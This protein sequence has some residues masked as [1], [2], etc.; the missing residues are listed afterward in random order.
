MPVLQPSREPNTCQLP[1]AKIPNRSLWWGTP[2]AQ[3]GTING[4]TVKSSFS[5]YAAT[6]SKLSLTCPRTFLTN[7]PTRTCLSN[8]ST[9]FRPEGERIGF[10]LLLPLSQSNRH[11]KKNCLMLLLVTSGFVKT[12]DL[13]F[14]PRLTDPESTMPQYQLTILIVGNKRQ[15]AIDLELTA[16]VWS[17]R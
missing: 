12:G 1:F 10:A 5:I 15:V 4:Q 6:A 3:A 11:I 8:D 7:A 13:G 9:Q 2:T 14:E 17:T 16:I